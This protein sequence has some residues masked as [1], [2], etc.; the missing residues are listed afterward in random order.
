MNFL[1]LFNKPA[2]IAAHRGARSIAPE[3]TLLALKKSVGH[4]D[5][6]EVDVQLSRDGVGVIMHDDTLGRTT[7]I[8]EIE[9]FKER[10]PYR[11]CDFT[12]KELSLLDYGSWFYA[13][14]PFGEIRK[15][16]VDVKKTGFEPLL[17]LQTLLHFIQQNR[18]F[19]N[20][21]IKDMHKNFKDLFVVERVLG[22]ITKYGVEDFVLISSFRHQYLPLSKSIAPNIPTAALAEGEHPAG[23]IRYLRDLQVDAY[24]IDE[25]LADKER[26]AE[27]KKAGFFVNVYTVN[28]SKRAQ[29]FFA[30]GVNG[31][32]SDYLP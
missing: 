27:L 10:A 30:M 2:L 12:F 16:K 23:L 24:N 5:F 9:A 18:V 13:K 11:V 1:N 26:V 21:E 14:D 22:E 20:I 6:M 3:N 19:V 8:R 17:S 25:R 28:D 7:D 29:E 31:V 32:F 4:C 15:K